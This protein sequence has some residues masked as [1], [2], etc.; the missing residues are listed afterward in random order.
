[1]G[2]GWAATRSNE[3]K[4]AQE[5]DENSTEQLRQENNHQGD[6]IIGFK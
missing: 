3:A 4:S 2:E 6:L 5:E 1:M